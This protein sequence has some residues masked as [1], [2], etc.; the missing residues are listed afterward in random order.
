MDIEG[1][2]R[3]FSEK[4][5]SMGRQDIQSQIDKSLE[6]LGMQKISIA[7]FLKIYEEANATLTRT[8]NTVVR[9]PKPIAKRCSKPVPKRDIVKIAYMPFTGR[10]PV[11]QDVINMVAEA[12]R[13]FVRRIL[14]ACG[15]LVRIRE[16]EYEH[17]NIR[18][19]SRPRDEMKARDDLEYVER[20]SNGKREIQVMDTTNDFARSLAKAP[21][22]KR[23][24]KRNFATVTEAA[25]IVITPELFK[26]ALE[27]C[28]KTQGSLKKLPNPQMERWKGNLGL[29]SI[30]Y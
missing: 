12:T 13:Q 30:I 9:V 18:Y 11:S 27:L 29:W 19:T 5:V 6:L 28:V 21:K 8:N 25:H 24:T 7:Q 3:T 2:F 14:D 15:K 23:K 17:Q 26:M 1:F 4:C 16:E 20:N 10:P 22:K